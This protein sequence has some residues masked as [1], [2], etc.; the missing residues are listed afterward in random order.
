MIKVSHFS[1]KLEITA[2]LSATLAPPKIPTN[3]LTGFS[4][5]SPK[6]LSSFSTKKPE[7]LGK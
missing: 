4:T 5:A 7:A 1:S 3:G 6:N 2:S